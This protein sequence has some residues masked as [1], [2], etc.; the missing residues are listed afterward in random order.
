MPAQAK[1]K[2][3]SQNNQSKKGW[4]HCLSNRALACKYK[5]LSL[6]PSITKKKKSKRMLFEG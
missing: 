1:G 6:N 4:R 3:L 5:A 2:T